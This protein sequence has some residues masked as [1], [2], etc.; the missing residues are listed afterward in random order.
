[1]G[2]WASDQLSREAGVQGSPSPLLDVLTAVLKAQQTGPE[3]LRR[4]GGQASRGTCWRWGVGRVVVVFWEHQLFGGSVIGP[5]CCLL[6]SLALDEKQVLGSGIENP[7]LRVEAVPLP[8]SCCLLADDLCSV[9]VMPEAL[10]PVTLFLLRGQWV[11][12]PRLVHHGLALWLLRSD[13]VFLLSV[14]L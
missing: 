7:L 2:E 5:S 14:R 1:M 10:G 13:L 8:S 6:G 3:V 11:L 4:A 12:L 9:G